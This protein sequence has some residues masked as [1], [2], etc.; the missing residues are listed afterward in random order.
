MRRWAAVYHVNGDATRRW[1]FTF[2]AE[3]MAD[4]RAD[5]CKCADE[6][7]PTRASA[8]AHGRTPIQHGR[9]HG[10]TRARARV[11]PRAH[12]RT[13]PYEILPPRFNEPPRRMERRPRPHRNAHSGSGIVE[14]RPGPDPA[15]AATEAWRR[16]DAS[17]YLPAAAAARAA[18]YLRAVASSSRSAARRF[19]YLR[20]TA[21]LSSRR[22]SRRG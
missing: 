12:T 8:R 18:S 10:R 16:R 1:R 17:G 2:A 20:A 11:G 22:G 7:S 6:R 3:L 9:T 4:V 14:A 21:S 5:G 13:C 15:V 19:S